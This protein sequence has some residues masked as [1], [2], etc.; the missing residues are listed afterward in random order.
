[1]AD[2][3]KKLDP[4][5]HVGG[6]P[7]VSENDAFRGVYVFQPKDEFDNNIGEKKVIEALNEPQAQAFIH[8]GYRGATEAE[9]KEYRDRV[10][11]SK[12]AK[13]AKTEE[14]EVSFEQD[15]DSLKPVKGANK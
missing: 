14:T 1:M 8:L 13:T 3:L 2:A 4:K 12:G 7:E 11:D 15:G 5:E 6:S 10:K 9:T